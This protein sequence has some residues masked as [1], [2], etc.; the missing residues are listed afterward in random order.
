M[1]E[2]TATAT[3]PNN[4]GYVTQWSQVEPLVLDI[5]FS[6][7]FLFCSFVIFYLGF[8]WATKAFLRK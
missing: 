8:T 2:A 4:N 5:D 1:F 7:F 3:D 6:G